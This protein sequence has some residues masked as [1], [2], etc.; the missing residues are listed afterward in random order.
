MSSNKFEYP[1]KAQII[2]QKSKNFFFGGKRRSK[3]F[4]SRIGSRIEDPDRTIL[5]QTNETTNS[6]KLLI[7]NYPNNNSQI[8]RH[9][10]CK[11]AIEKKHT[12]V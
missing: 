6:F 10:T 3:N 7:Y 5:I 11:Y 12:Q 1:S 8:H 9:N 4:Q 2:G